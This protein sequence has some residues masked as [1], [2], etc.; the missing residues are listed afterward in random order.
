MACFCH[1]FRML[2]STKSG[3]FL[4]AGRPYFRA[5]FWER[6][7]LTHLTMRSTLS[8]ISAWVV[9]LPKLNRSEEEM[10]SSGSPIARSTGD[11]SLDPLAHAEPVEQ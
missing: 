10:T 4:T 2:Q 3:P 6:K 5:D 8:S 1:F 9:G 11:G 7:R